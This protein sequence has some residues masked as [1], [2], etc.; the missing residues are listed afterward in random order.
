[1]KY[2]AIDTETTGV[3]DEA[4][5]LEAA[6][7]FEDTALDPLPPVEQLPFLVGLF[8]PRRRECWAP[9]VAQMHVQNGLLAE[10]TKHA[11]SG[12]NNG[13]SVREGVTWYAASD[14]KRASFVR[15]MVAWLARQYAAGAGN[16]K[17]VAAGK[18]F[19]SF[20]RRFL[21]PTLVKLFHYRSID[22]GSVFIDWTRDVPPSLDDLRGQKVGH[23]A[24]EDARDVVRVLRR[25][26]AK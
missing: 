9:E 13:A 23:R 12:L 8:E 3:S 15:H 18:N 16:V 6:F 25:S 1:M 10:I 19:G 7:V 11:S 26:Y 5:L 14:E 4:E 17:Y 2:V 22:P 21:P 20:D 24:L